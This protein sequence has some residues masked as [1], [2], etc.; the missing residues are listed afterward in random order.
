MQ[1]SKGG[2]E[3]A[4]Y[5]PLLFCQPGT[6]LCFSF[7]C[8]FSRFLCVGR[9]KLT[10]GFATP[11][12]GWRGVRAC[13]GGKEVFTF[14]KINFQKLLYRSCFFCRMP[15]KDKG[16]WVGSERWQPFGFSRLRHFIKK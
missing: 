10:R 2:E 11:L 16:F 1:K 13:K 8:V 7:C 5:I 15:C 12:K 9:G 14:L 4:V 6:F 3:R